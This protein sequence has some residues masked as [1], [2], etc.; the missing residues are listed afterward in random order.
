MKIAALKGQ[1]AVYQKVEEEVRNAASSN[2]PEVERASKEAGPKAVQGRKQGVM[3]P[4]DM[5][6]EQFE[7]TD[8]SPTGLSKGD[9]ADVASEMLKNFGNNEKSSH[10][11]TGEQGKSYMVKSY[12]HAAHL[13]G[14]ENDAEGEYDMLKGY[15]HAG[16]SSGPEHEEE[17]GDPAMVHGYSHAGRS[18]GPEHEEEGDPAMVHGY[19]HAGRWSGPEHEEEAEVTARVRGRVTDG[20]R[21]RSRVKVGVT[22]RVRARV[23]VITRVMVLG[24]GPWGG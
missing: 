6:Q 9:H 17:E 19:S 4:D 22:A 18:S 24:I 2:V 8:S 20:I 7:E 13:S 12:D 3:V 10:S 1:L 5:F 23:S 16:R 15:S 11:E 21:D 14:S